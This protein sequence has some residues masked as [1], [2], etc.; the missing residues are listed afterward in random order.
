MTH[1]ST[2]KPRIKHVM[3]TPKTS[4]VQYQGTTKMAGSKKKR[5]KKTNEREMA[6][7]QRRRS[8][9]ASSAKLLIN[10]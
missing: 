1:L 5:R 10:L 6:K 9:A 4:G 3:D 8:E 2:N 7:K